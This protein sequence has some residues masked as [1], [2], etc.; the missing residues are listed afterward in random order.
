MMDDVAKI[1]SWLSLFIGPGQ[2]TELR[3]LDVQEGRGFGWTE[4][5]FYD[6][7]HLPDMA[8]AALEISK[9]AK[10]VY[11]I[12]NPINPA[13]LARCANRLKRAGKDDAVSDNHIV[14][15]RWLL[16]DADPVRVEGVSATEME[17]AAALE[18]IMR[19]KDKAL[20]LFASRV[21]LADS[22]NGYHAVCQ[23]D[24]PTNDNGTC[25]RFLNWLGERFDTE[26]VTIDRKVFNPARIV[27]L[28]GT[29]SR[30]GDSTHERPHRPSAAIS[31]FK[32]S[33]EVRH[34]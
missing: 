6:H 16:I 18:V 34:L 28:Y 12:P 1:A 30:K 24:L 23:I 4:A 20:E 22:G 15:R 31:E 2:V 29:L 25:R 11:F 14:R 27:K 13:L 8:K 21:I 19:A 5:G 33:G 10:G 26:Q 32:A 3:A 17:K 7:E 9:R